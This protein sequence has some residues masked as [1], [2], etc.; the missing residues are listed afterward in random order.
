MTKNIRY[1]LFKKEIGGT[2]YFSKMETKHGSKH[3]VWVDSRLKCCPDMPKLYQSRKRAENMANT[4]RFNSDYD[5]LLESVETMQLPNG[6]CE[7]KT[8][9]IKKFYC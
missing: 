6:E 4:L 5:I 8:T 7:E 3:P 2:Y 9:F 1:R